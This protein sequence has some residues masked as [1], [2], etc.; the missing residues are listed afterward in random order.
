MAVKASKARLDSTRL[1]PP[2]PEDA[3]IVF[4]LKEFS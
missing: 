2:R 1:L 4:S 3:V